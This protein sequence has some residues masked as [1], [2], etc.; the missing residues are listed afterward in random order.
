[1]MKRSAPIAL[2]FVFAVSLRAEDKN[3]M[4]AVV[5]NATYVMVT[6]Y[7]GCDARRPARCA[8]RTGQ[9]SEMGLVEEVRSKVEAS[10]KKKKP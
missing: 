7:S 1:M 9:D 3:A 8:E 6:T 5:A 10:E 2:L 4:S